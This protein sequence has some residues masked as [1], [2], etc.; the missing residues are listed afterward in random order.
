MNIQGEWSREELEILQKP[1]GRTPDR[2][3]RVLCPGPASPAQTDPDR[4]GSPL[5]LGW[6]EIRPAQEMTMW[7]AP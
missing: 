7:S 3:H 1:F 6:P 5:Q 4:T 2:M